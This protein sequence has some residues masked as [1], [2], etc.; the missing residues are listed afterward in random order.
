MTTYDP[1]NDVSRQELASA[2]LT[3]LEKAGFKEQEGKKG[4]EKIFSY[5]VSDRIRILVYTTIVSDKVRNLGADAIRT[6]SVYTATDGKDRGLVKMTRVNRVGTIE[7]IVNRTLDRMRE[8]WKVCARP[9]V[10]KKC[11]APTFISSAGNKICCELCWL[12]KDSV[13]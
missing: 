3:M 9:E 11:G 2:L 6:T 12:K 1:L 5:Q 4:E 10:C 7:D 8:V 13:E